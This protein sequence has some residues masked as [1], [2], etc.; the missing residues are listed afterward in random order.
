MVSSIPDNALFSDEKIIV[1]EYFDAHQDWDVPIPGFFIIAARRDVH[2][3]IDFTD[4]ERDEFFQLVYTIRAGM[5]EVLGIE[6]VLLIE[7]EASE[8]QF[9]LWLFPWHEWM[10]R[11]H[12]KTRHVYDA[13]DYATAH[14]QT[15]EVAVAIHESVEK[16]KE[17]IKHQL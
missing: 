7:N 14:M 9:H 5:R 3:L 2:S 11:W 10:D 17:Y 6:K 12:Y 16:M 1:T 13:I 4:A 8:W 15:E